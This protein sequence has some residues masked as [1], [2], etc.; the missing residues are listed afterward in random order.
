MDVTVFKD[1]FKYE[2]HF[3]KGNNVGGLKKEPYNYKHSGTL[4]RWKPDLEV[5]T[6]I[7]IPLDFFTTVL[8]KQAVVNAG[9]EICADRRRERRKV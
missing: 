4:Q 8:K 6:D 2:L 1:G 9:P 5:F 7:N 3:E